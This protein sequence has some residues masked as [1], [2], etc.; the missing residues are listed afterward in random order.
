MTLVCAVLDVPR[1]SFYYR[2]AVAD[3][4]ALKAALEALAARWPTYGYRRLTALLQRAG[5]DVNHKRVTRLMRAMGLTVAPKRQRKRTTDSRHNGPRFPNLVQDLAVVR[6]DQV[7]VADITYI[8]L[9]RDFVYLAAVMDVYTRAVRGWQLSRQL[10]SSLTQTA[11]QRALRHGRPDIHHSDQ[12]VQYVAQDYLALL[13]DPPTQ[14]SMADVGYAERLM[15]TIKEEEVELTEYADFH[16]AYH[17]LG[18]FLDNVYM[19]KRIHSA[20]G[21][22]TPAEFEAQWLQEQPAMEVID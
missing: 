6:P 16:E 22:L 4:T 3:E 18:C 13:A 2:A 5:W 15:R 11:L 14:V 1:S 10:D 19:H 20:L 7:W 9:R 12:G 21:Y 17:Q 8:R